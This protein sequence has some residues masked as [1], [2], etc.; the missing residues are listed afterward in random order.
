[1]SNNWLILKKKVFLHL[2]FNSRMFL[3]PDLTVDFPTCNL[4]SSRRIEFDLVNASVVSMFST[5]FCDLEL[6]FAT[7]SPSFAC[8]LPFRF[9]L[10]VKSTSK[11]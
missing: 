6:L 4:R 3:G 11:S 8:E 1:M 5:M 7:P 9:V 10:P 2:S